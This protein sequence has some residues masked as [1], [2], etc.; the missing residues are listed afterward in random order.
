[1]AEFEPIT[2]FIKEHGGFL[3]YREEDEDGSWSF[4]AEQGPNMMGYC[5]TVS[6]VCEEIDEYN[7]GPDDSRARQAEGWE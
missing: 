4:Y 5:D 7:R 1:M 6:E 3:V 2:T